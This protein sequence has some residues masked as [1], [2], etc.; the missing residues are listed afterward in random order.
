MKSSSIHTTPQEECDRIISRYAAR[1]VIKDKKLTELRHKAE[2]LII[3]AATRQHPSKVYKQI[4]I[5]LYAAIWKELYPLSQIIKETYSKILRYKRTQCIERDD[6]LS[7]ELSIERAALELDA[8]RFLLYQD[9]TDSLSY[10]QK[11]E[12]AKLVVADIKD[13]LSIIQQGVD[14]ITQLLE[15]EHPLEELS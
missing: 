4:C 8:V 9:T 12:I 7:H 5:E 2:S 15:A 14:S 3:S 6:K 10:L 13:T 1:A 11:V